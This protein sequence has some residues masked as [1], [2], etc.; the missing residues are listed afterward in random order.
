MVHPIHCKTLENHALAPSIRKIEHTLS[1]SSWSRFPEVKREGQ[2]K[3]FQLAGRISLFFFRISLF[4]LDNL[5]CQGYMSCPGGTV[6]VLWFV[7]CCPFLNLFS[8]FA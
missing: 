4:L 8:A 2:P 7:G 6:C 1:G 5:S 3:H